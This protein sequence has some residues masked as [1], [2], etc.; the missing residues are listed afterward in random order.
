MEVDQHVIEAI[1]EPLLC[2]R[3][4][5]HPMLAVQ[6]PEMATGGAPIREVKKA[7]MEALI[8]SP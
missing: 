1:G 5:D 3:K 6:P 4:A 2:V 8:I 7:E